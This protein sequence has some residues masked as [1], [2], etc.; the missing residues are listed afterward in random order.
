M[1]VKS[2]LG[3]IVIGGTLS[4]KVG[5]LTSTKK[6]CMMVHICNFSYVEG[7]RRRNAVQEYN[8]R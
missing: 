5:D 4:Q 2:H 7:V 8:L 6:P 1:L 3:K